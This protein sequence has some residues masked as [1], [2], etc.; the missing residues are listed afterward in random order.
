MADKDEVKSMLEELIET[1]EEKIENNDKLKD[2][3]QEFERN[4]AINFEDDGDY[5]FQLSDGEISDLKEGKTKRAD[6]TI[7]TDSETLHALMSGDM[8]A[9]E[10]YARKKVRVDAPFLDLLKIKDMF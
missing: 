9:M 3:L 6:I 2:R 4:I 7:K 10:A 5:S 1:F 8:K